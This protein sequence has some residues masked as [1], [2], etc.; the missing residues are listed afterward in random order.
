[1]SINAFFKILPFTH[2]NRRNQLYQLLIIYTYLLLL[3]YYTTLREIFS[4]IIFSIA[5]HCV[6]Y[7]G[8]RMPTCKYGE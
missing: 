4:V 3:I 5:L 1:M 8:K 6:S 7:I 2:A